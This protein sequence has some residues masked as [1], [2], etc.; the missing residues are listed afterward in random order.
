[1]S[2]AS[3]GDTPGLPGWWP[4]RYGEGDEAGALNE[5]SAGGIVRAARLVRDGRVFDIARV[6]GVERLGAG[7]V[8][9]PVDAEKAL[10]A[11]GLRVEP[12]DG[13]LFHTGWGAQWGVADDV[14]SAGEPG[15]GAALGD[16]LADH[17]V[18]LTGCD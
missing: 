10:A 16:W 15:P 4:S 9:T 7:D 18:A 6:R 3:S 11:S 17:R 8:I 13:V 1:M 2:A 5:I 12:G 14:Y